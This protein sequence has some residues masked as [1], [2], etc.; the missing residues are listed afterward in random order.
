MALYGGDYCLDENTVSMKTGLIFDIYNIGRPWNVP[1][2]SRA[3]L[4]AILSWLAAL[5]ASRAAAHFWHFCSRLVSLT[6]NTVSAPRTHNCARLLTVATPVL[7][8]A[9]KSHGAWQQ[10]TS[11]NYCAHDKCGR[12]DKQT[13]KTQSN[14]KSNRFVHF[15]CTWLVTKGTEMV[16]SVPSQ[17]SIAEGSHNHVLAVILWLTLTHLP[18]SHPL[19]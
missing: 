17:V 8:A 11:C 4:A 15:T 6:S 3:L 9:I 10:W 12:T 1:I 19:C 14:H 2:H 13:Q 16:D 5:W 7:K 18:L